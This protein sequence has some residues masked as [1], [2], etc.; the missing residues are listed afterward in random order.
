[1]ELEDVSTCENTV[2]NFFGHALNNI[3]SG[4]KGRPSRK[5]PAG[6][7]SGKKQVEILHQ[8]LNYSQRIPYFKFAP[9]W[10]CP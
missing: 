7:L 8:G 10:N 1:M 9:M 6:K 5:I 4:E 3:E 2:T